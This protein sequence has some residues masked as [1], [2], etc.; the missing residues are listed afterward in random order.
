MWLFVNNKLDLILYK[1]YA[2]LRRDVVTTYL[3]MLWWVLEP[4][5]Y[6][7][8]FYLVFAVG[9]RSG[10]EG[11]V[12]FLLCGLA[13]WKWF[14][15]TVSQASSS[16]LLHRGLI[17]QVYIPK[18]VLPMI[19]VSVNT[20]KFLVILCLLL[21]FLSL[22]GEG[23]AFQW[24]YLLPVLLVEFMLI[25]GLSLFIASVVPFLMDLRVLVANGLIMLMFMSGI[26]FSVQDFPADVQFYF[27][28]N[29]MV[30][31][32]EAFRVVL[33]EA[34]APNW[35]YLIYVALLSLVFA[36]VGYCVFWRYD[37]YYPKVML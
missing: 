23:P 36:L 17:Q 3:G 2:E 22:T 37:R 33:L 25:T 7:A 20:V 16:V 1:A 18:V 29:P 10:G 5:M 34:Q 21:V 12:G 26:F 13:S 14:A 35:Q 8:A 9:I 31:I 15:S 24:L 32:I 27:Y 11:F 19:S 28:L 6:M 30:S 4:L